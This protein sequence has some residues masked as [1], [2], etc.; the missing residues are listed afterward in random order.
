MAAEEV[1]I[2]VQE[3]LV[4]VELGGVVVVVACSLQEEE[5]EVFWALSLWDPCS[6][7]HLYWIVLSQNGRYP[8]LVTVS[9]YHQLGGSVGDLSSQEW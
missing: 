8:S 9:L 6:G 4:E 2:C 7:D 3:R 1:L 5:V